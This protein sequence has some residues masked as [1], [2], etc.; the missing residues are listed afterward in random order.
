[1]LNVIGNTFP[2]ETKNAVWQK[3]LAEMIPFYNREMEGNGKEFK[4][5]ERK[6]DFTLGLSKNRGS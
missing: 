6:T 3:K 4:A 5:L 2:E 1:M